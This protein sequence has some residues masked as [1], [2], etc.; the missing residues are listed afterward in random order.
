MAVY[1]LVLDHQRSID[2]DVLGI[3]IVNDKEESSR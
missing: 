3:V 2:S 1:C